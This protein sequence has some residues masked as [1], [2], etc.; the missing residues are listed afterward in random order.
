MITKPSVFGVRRMTSKDKVIQLGALS[1]LV[2][3]L[4]ENLSRALIAIETDPPDVSVLE[5]ISS[6][7]GKDSAEVSTLVEYLEGELRSLPDGQDKEIA[8]CVV[9]SAAS[10]YELATQVNYMCAR[11]KM[12]VTVA[13]EVSLAQR[14][15]DF[16]PP[17]PAISI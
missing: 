12:A 10:V 2:G 16:P 5:K 14:D 6:R 13:K 8:L 9:R 7:L 1:G 15:P 11:A 17:Q 3:K 4:T